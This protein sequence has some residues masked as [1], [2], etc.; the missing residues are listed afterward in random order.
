MLG[1]GATQLEDDMHRLLSSLF[2]QG[3]LDDHFSQLQRLQD[4]DSPNFVVE[5]VSI[6]FRESEKLLTTLRALLLERECT[7]YK[8]MGTHLNRLMGSSSSIGANRVRNVCVALR[9]F[10]ERSNRAGC[11]NSLE[12]LEYEQC[13]LKSK[14]HELFQLEQQRLM[15]SG[16]GYGYHS[17]MLD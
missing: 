1:L 15:A 6:Y 14:L 11:I 16:L 17:I 7:D 2:H 4:H 10:S 13:L 3:V 9:T 5:V 8:K 12:Q